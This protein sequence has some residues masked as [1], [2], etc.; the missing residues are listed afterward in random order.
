MDI[1]KLTLIGRLTARPD[2]KTSE[3]GQRV[4]TF[5]IATN[6]LWQD[7]A[8]RERRDETE[9]HVVVV[10]GTLAEIVETYLAKGSRVYVEGRLAHR[11]FTDRNGA[12]RWAVN[13]LADEIIMLGT[14]GA[15]RKNTPAGSV[16]S[17]SATG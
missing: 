6:Y 7:A 13:V 17:P 8:S 12:E 11:Q 10:L 9:F 2:C 5:T 16:A 3:S 15:E 4:T 14:H 1:N